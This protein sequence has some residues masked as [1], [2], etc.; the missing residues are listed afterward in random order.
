MNR[1][2]LILL[3]LVTWLSVFAQ[4]QFSGL[5]Q[6]LTVPM[7]LSPALICYAALTH[8]FGITVSYWSSLESIAAWRAHAEHRIAQTLGRERWYEHFELRI[9]RVEQSRSFC[10]PQ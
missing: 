3:F 8:G 6:W 1:F 5:R 4:T 10:A 9:A 2:T 7:A